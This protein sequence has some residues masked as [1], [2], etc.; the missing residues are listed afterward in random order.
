[1]T[2]S[3][4]NFL[5]PHHPCGKELRLRVF[6][7]S[8][9]GRM[10]YKRTSSRPLLG[11]GDP[12]AIWNKEKLPIQKCQ[13]R[14][15]NPAPQSPPACD[16]GGPRRLDGRHLVALRGSVSDPSNLNHAEYPPP[17]WRRRLTTP[18]TPGGAILE[19]S[20]VKLPLEEKRWS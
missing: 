13:K 6:V 5:S 8:R 3:A 14:V 7:T 18:K 15:H 4:G 20:K 12:R 17:A 19:E 1:M 2:H 9:G 16:S 10:G 11:S